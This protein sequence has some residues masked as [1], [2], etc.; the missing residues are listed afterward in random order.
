MTQWID[1]EK[2]LP[3]EGERVMI[4]VGSSQVLDDHTG[5]VCTVFI[6]TKTGPRWETDGGIAFANPDVHF[7]MPLPERP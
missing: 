1:R 7:W 5:H 6:A 3:E 2:K 4:A